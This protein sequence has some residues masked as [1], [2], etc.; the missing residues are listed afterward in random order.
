MEE[1]LRAGLVL[2]FIALDLYLVYKTRK[3]GR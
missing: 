2:A 3:P 1:S